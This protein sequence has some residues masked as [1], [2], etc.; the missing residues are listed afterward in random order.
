MET[1]LNRISS[2]SDSDNVRYGGTISQES[3]YKLQQICS[4]SID[5][6]AYVFFPSSGSPSGLFLSYMYTS[7]GGAIWSR[8]NTTVQLA[9]TPYP[10][11]VVEGVFGD[12]WCWGR[13]FAN[14][15]QLLKAEKGSYQVIDNNVN[16]TYVDW[17]NNYTNGMVCRYEWNPGGSSPNEFAIKSNDGIVISSGG[18]ISSWTRSRMFEYGGSYY[19]ISWIPPN[20][21]PP[22][23]E[24]PYGGVEI[25]KTG[26]GDIT[27]SYLSATLQ[28]PNQA[29][30][31]SDASISDSGN[32]AMA[33]TLNVPIGILPSRP[34]GNYICEMT[35]SQAMQS[36]TLPMT[37]VPLKVWNLDVGTSVDMGSGY[38]VPCDE[39]SLCHDSS[40]NL[41]IG[42]TKY[43]ISMGKY[44]GNTLVYAK[45]SGAS[46]DLGPGD[47][48][49]VLATDGTLADY[50]GINMVKNYKMDDGFLCSF[51]ANHTANGELCVGFKGT[52]S[53]KSVGGVM[54]VE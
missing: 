35:L 3:F 5:G 7:D 44:Y 54:Y 39:C 30:F 43:S 31:M 53:D 15:L 21:S 6:V 16:S 8:V 34:A 19:L 33:F 38:E 27:K 29:M 9:S 49:Y 26:G 42:I 46:L 41:W 20:A 17:N 52:A 50:F 1:T 40:N 10:L 47:M 14:P 36:Q 11:C 48:G 13:G 25:V 51:S 4:T 24:L 28:I 18:T 45:K 22:C 37:L 12:V 2:W 23:A 32:L